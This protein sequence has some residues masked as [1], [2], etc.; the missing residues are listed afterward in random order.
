MRPARR[1]L[2]CEEAADVDD[3]GTFSALLDS[4]YTLQFAF[5]SGEP[6][7]APYPDCG[8]LAAGD[9][10]DFGCETPPICP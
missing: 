3:N 7:P 2:P 1:A 6:I 4:L 10:N 9:T 5:A 8:P